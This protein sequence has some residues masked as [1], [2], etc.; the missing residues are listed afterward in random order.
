VE[1][2]TIGTALRSRR[3]SLNLDQTHAASLVGMSRTSYSSYERDLQRP[4]VEVLPGLAEFLDISIDDVLTLYGGTCI[5]AMRPSL[6]LFLA[7]RD[8]DKAAPPQVTGIAPKVQAASA[9][10]T[11]PEVPA[12]PDVPVSPEVPVAP[13]LP[14]A[15]EVPVEPEVPVALE[16]PAE[17]SSASIFA[18]ELSD[19]DRPSV[20]GSAKST[21]QKDRTSSPAKEKSGKKKKHKKSKK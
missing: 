7:T 17:P 6:E 13:E 19:D 11:A 2:S 3:Q 15:P 21:D 4:S 5:E 20:R 16:I 14:D 8:L 1:F 9:E 10:D 18:N 12:E